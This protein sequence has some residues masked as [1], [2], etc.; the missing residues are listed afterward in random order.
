MLP[1]NQLSFAV[2]PLDHLKAT[3][4]T[5]CHSKDHPDTHLTDA[6]TSATERVYEALRAAIVTRSLLPGQTLSRSDLAREHGVSPTP[7]REAMLRLERE[8]FIA[9][10][11]QSRTV[12]THIDVAEV[13]QMHVLRTA[14]ESEV[15]TRLARRRTPPDL[16]AARAACTGDVQVPKDF[17]ARDDAY[18]QALF[19]AAGLSLLWSKTAALYGALD[20]CHALAS[21]SPDDIA[22]AIAFHKDIL[23]RIEARDPDGAVQAMR[24]HLTDGIAGLAEWQKTHPEL[25]TPTA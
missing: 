23:A 10:F 16:G 1:P 9:V 19:E 20:R 17:P 24:A 4:E 5:L 7:L 21:P 14:L 13:H 25:F 6:H 3:G 2:P 15:V 11:P 12:V 18:H 22:R 8:G